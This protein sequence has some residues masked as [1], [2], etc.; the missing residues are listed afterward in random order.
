MKGFSMKK[1]RACILLFFLI[2]S[3]NARV[4]SQIPQMK[5]MGDFEEGWQNNWL[6]REFA[7]RPTHYEV[8]TE[9]TNKVLMATSTNSASALWRPLALKAGSHGTISW[10]WK[11]GNTLSTDTEEKTKLGDDYAARVF[12]VFEPHLVSWK[13]RAICYVWSAKEPA[14]SIYSNPYAETV[15]MVVVESGKDKKGKWLQQE[16]DF[17]ADYQKIF[18][19]DPEMI[20]AVAVMV[21]TDNTNQEATTW[22]DDIVLE[23]GTPKSTEEKRPPIL[24]RK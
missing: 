10:R 14:G 12:V 6:P 22:F 7:V 13:T 2:F 11:I 15:S 20:T 17:V 1:G 19:K 5:L 8:V 21:D 23:V 18:G 16:R 24:F 9:D 4:L 3:L